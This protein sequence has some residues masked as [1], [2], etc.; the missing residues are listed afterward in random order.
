[1]P[2][3]AQDTSATSPGTG[4]AIKQLQDQSALLAAQTALL[5]A[6]KA[7]LA[8]QADLEAQKGAAATVAAAAAKAERDARDK[9]LVDAVDTLAG[10][11]SKL[12]SGS[13][14]V[15]DDFKATPA[16]TRLSMDALGATC[17]EVARTIGPSL[18]DKTVVFV[19]S[20]PG[21]VD[22]YAYQYFLLNAAD[23]ETAITD[24]A[25][26]AAERGGPERVGLSE[27][28][29]NRLGVTGLVSTKMAI[30]E[31]ASL[32]AALPGAVGTLLGFFRADTTEHAGTASNPAS[33]AATLFAQ[34]A[35]L[36][37]V[38]PSVDA[39]AYAKF[40]GFDT[41]KTV[42]A[43]ER[44]I[45]LD[46]ALGDALEEIGTYLRRPQANLATFKAEAAE[47]E[48]AA[49]ALQAKLTEV[50]TSLAK[51]A[52]AS[53][54]TRLTEQK[55]TL[56]GQIA[57]NKAQGETV[58]KQVADAQLI[59]DVITAWQTKFS[60]QRSSLESFIAGLG[61][62]DSNGVPKLVALI[63]AELLQS[64][65]FP[66]DS[67]TMASRADS[68]ALRLVSLKIVQQ[69][70]STVQKTFAFQKRYYAN[71]LVSIAYQVATP[72]GRIYAQGVVTRSTSERLRTPERA[73]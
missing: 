48:G 67:G 33:T 20:I 43:S 28:V 49:T 2:M 45:A 39:A 8:A 42:K 7:N 38:Y 50:E 40:E 63:K 53:A 13:Q 44:L 23:R 10:A 55:R 12:P 71:A 11:A 69:P 70:Q 1:M 56:E 3:N 52:D 34:E 17:G 46:A 72:D 9:A 37:N 59:V 65:C 27:P 47:V 29:L 57:A 31:V 16:S 22:T 36:T 66:G 60:Q 24:L 4:D 62:A 6:Q 19:D 21:P 32:V 73:N 25:K 15:S 61:V 64:L 54:R 35:G 68:S 18:R 14:S 51:E 5:A 41:L 26:A 58:G 30:G